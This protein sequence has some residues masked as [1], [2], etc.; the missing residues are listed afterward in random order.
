MK[1]LFDTEPVYSDRNIQSIVNV[2]EKLGIEYNLKPSTPFSSKAD[3]IKLDGKL[4]QHWLRPKRVNLGASVGNYPRPNIPRIVK[5]SFK[6]E[7][8]LEETLK[9]YEK[10]D[11]YFIV[12]V[13]VKNGFKFWVNQ[14]HNIDKKHWRMNPDN[15]Y[16]KRLML[17]KHLKDVPYKFI[18]EDKLK[19]EINEN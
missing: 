9:F 13:P 7:D 5:F 8:W 14:Y 11:V 17:N 16:A 1:P 18:T 6:P 15:K 2:F 19:K 10:W 4:F 12:I 3:Y